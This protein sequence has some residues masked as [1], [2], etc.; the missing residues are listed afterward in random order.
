MTFTT[1]AQAAWDAIP[2]SDR[3]QLL[4]GG[5]CTRC[6]ATRR[7]TLDDAEIRD[8]ELAL[9]GRCDACG[10]RVV[11]LTRLRSEEREEG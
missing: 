1:E 8:G 2:E 9:I 5:F 7:F 10:S 3:E 6:L 4:S 11:K